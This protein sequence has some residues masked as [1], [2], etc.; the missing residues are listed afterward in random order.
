RRLHSFPT[1]RSSDLKTLK[2]LILVVFVGIL[3][4]FLINA[5]ASTAQNESTIKPSVKEFEFCGEKV[6]IHIADV[7]ER[8]DRELTINRN[9]HASTELVI[10]RANRYFPIIEPILEKQDR[11]STRLNSSH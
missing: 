2:S 8:L 3:S 10:K 7:Q 11:K 1:R 5:V 6:P 9:L 4:F